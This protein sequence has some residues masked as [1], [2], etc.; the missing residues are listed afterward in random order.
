VHFRR[1]GE[2][3][4]ENGIN[5]RDLNTL[6]APRGFLI[7]LL[8]PADRAEDMLLGLQKAFEERWVPKYGLRRAQRMFLWHAVWSVVGFWINWIR[9]QLDLLKFFAS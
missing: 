6:K 3:F 9:R 4:A 7:D 2:K 1:L 8:V 5:S